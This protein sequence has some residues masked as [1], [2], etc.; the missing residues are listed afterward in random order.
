L[1]V[2][3][4]LEGGQLGWRCKSRCKELRLNQHK[5]E[6]GEHRTNVWDP[7]GGVGEQM[8]AVAIESKDLELGR[9]LGKSKGNGNFKAVVRNLWVTTPLAHLYL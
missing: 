4:Y 1:G 5:G 7:R 9:V 3:I 2:C 6:G 8:E